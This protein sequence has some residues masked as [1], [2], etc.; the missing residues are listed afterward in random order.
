M[1]SL[2]PRIGQGDSLGR[3]ILEE[4]A[5]I[6]GQPFAATEGLTVHNCKRSRQGHC[7]HV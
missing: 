4:G 6:V 7:G 1:E 3:G 5:A 2:R